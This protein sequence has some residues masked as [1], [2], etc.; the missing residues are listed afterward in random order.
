[1]GRNELNVLQHGSGSHTIMHG[2]YLPKGQEHVDNHTTMDHICCR[3][4]PS[5]LY[6]GICTTARQGCSTA[7]SFREDAQLTNAYQQNANI[8]ADAGASINAKPEWRF[9]RTT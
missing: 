6:K 4:A 9:M 3:I 1:M 2:A 8:V 5:E 7:R